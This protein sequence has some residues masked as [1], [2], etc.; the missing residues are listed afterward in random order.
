MLLS[1]KFKSV[2][3][4]IISTKSIRNLNKVYVLPSIY[5]TL[6]RELNYQTRLLHSN[7]MVLNFYHQIFQCNGNA[8]TE[9][10]SVTHL[11]PKIRCV[12]CILYFVHSKELPVNNFQKTYHNRGATVRTCQKTSTKNV[13][14]RIF[15]YPV[16]FSSSFF[17][18]K[19]KISWSINYVR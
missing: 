11:L 5:N 2:S 12:H 15:L 19:L 8:V 7:I 4:Q 6:Y 1:F 17:L 14:V 16:P 18:R 9:W 13:N 10:Q 3:K